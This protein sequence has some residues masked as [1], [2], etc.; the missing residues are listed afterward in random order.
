[1][2]FGVCDLAGVWQDDEQQIESIIVDY[3]TDIFHSQGQID[4]T[5]LIEVGEPV[6]TTDMNDFFTQ[7][8]KVDE[9]YRALK[10]MHPK[11]SPSPN[12]MP[13]LFYQHFL[14]LV[15]DCVTKTVLEF[16][17]HDITPQILMR[18]MFCL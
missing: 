7:E 11:K 16:L 15:G 1:M 18:L 10:Q 9:V 8:F 3:F 13:S 17:N 5:T 2:I 12:G 6:V 4:S 14:S